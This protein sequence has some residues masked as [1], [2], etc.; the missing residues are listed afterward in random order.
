LIETPE[1]PPI[2]VALEPAHNNFNSL[3]LIARPDRYYG[4]SDWIYRTEA[5]LSPELRQD[6]R[7]VIEGFYYI[8][9]P[10]RS[11][12]SFTAYIDDLANRNPFKMRNDLLEAYAAR[13]CYNEEK[14]AADVDFE[15]VMASLDNFLGFLAERFPPENTIIEVETVAYALLKDPPKMQN[16]IVSHMRTMWNQVLAA[17]WERIEPMLQE[18]VNAFRQLNLENYSKLEAMELVLEE[19]AT[20]DK[21]WTRK[22][23]R[24]ERIIFV[25]SAHMGPYH[26]VYMQNGTFWVLFGARSPAGIRTS[27]PE[28]SRA[29]ILV[30]LNALADD[31]RL[32]ILNIIAQQGTLSSGDI[33]SQLDL[34]QSAASRH[35]KQLS[36][37]GYLTERRKH[38]AKHYTL[39]PDRIQ[40]TLQAIS[41]FLLG[42]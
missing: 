12:Q 6:N 17:E 2:H 9:E 29:E 3:L 7:V 8:I 31:T 18:S 15:V 20:D 11:W 27:T 4:L 33:M 26:H 41:D 39:N 30:R 19:N 14:A 21:K 37:T 32:R 5:G 40:G 13:T 1:T 10:D 16:F 23:D 42:R 36:A 22:L 38:G 28:L 24:A 35:L 25:P 34:S